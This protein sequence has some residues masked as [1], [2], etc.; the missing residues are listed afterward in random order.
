MCVC[1]SPVC[2]VCRK[3]LQQHEDYQERL[4][5]VEAPGG[6][7]QRRNIW[8]NIKLGRYSLCNN[9]MYVYI[10]IY[11][12]YDFSVLSVPSVLMWCRLALVFLG[13]NEESGPTS[14]ETQ[15]NEVSLSFSLLM[16]CLFSDLTFALMFMYHTTRNAL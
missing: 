10:Y 7:S 13:F 11:I 3:F 12:V 6:W 4:Y 16:L 8:L 5:E 15:R 1:V 9:L 2:S 14:G